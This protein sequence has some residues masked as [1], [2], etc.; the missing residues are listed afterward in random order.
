VRSLIVLKI[1]LKLSVTLTILLSLDLS[2]IDLWTFGGV[3]L[4]YF[5]VFVLFLYCDL[6]MHWVKY[7]S[8]IWVSSYYATFS[9]VVNPSISQRRENKYL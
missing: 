4:S 5:F 6:H 8:F 2:V 9:W 7:P 1:R 3:R